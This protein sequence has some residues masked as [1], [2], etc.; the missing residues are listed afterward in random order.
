MIRNKRLP[1]F[2]SPTIGLMLRHSE[3]PKVVAVV[4]QLGYE[5]VKIVPKKC[6]N[7]EWNKVYAKDTDGEYLWLH[8]QCFVE[9]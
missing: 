8:G 4:E 2:K 7:K 9:S 3:I 5:E 6:R 1:S